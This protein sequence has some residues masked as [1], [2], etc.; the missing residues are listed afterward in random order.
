MAAETMRAFV[1]DSFDR[2]PSL[3]DFPAPDPDD[4]GLVAVGAAGLNPFDAV[5][6]AGRHPIGRPPLP[7]IVGREGIGVDRDGRRVFFEGAVPPF[8]SLAPA[9]L[10]RE[11]ASFEVR[12]D[13]DD[14]TAIALGAAGITAWLALAGRA[15][16]GP[17]D[18]VVVLGATG[19][20]GSAGVQ[21]A[22]LLGARRVV[23]V[24]RR[25]E[26]LE[27]ARARGADGSVQIDAE[28]DLAAAIE[29]AAEGS[30]DVVLDLL[31]GPPARAAL[32]VASPGARLVQVGSSA[33]PETPMPANPWRTR[34]VSLLGFSLL[35]A[36]QEAKADAYRDL[37]DHAA[38]G[39]IQVDTETLPFAE[40]GRAWELLLAGSDRKLV[41][42][43]DSS[44]PRHE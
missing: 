27:R 16:V 34:G 21:I 8:G 5:Y 26:A 19:A 3:S 9:A 28:E 4:R 41:L 37:L 7:S 20:V 30:V 39:R 14:A 25:R 44:V 32:Q 35:N 29:A 38:A 23:A 24:G 31:W 43:M 17:A 13:V 36:D 18:T 2:P 42:R 40:V 33:A 1:V 15:A 12:D 10:V 6:A 22:T 11:G